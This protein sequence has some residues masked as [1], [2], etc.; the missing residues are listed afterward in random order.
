MTTAPLLAL[1]P[2]YTNGQAMGITSVCS[3]HPQVIAAALALG[4][5]TG[6][7]VLIEATCNQVNQDGGYTG[8]RPA[9][10]RRFV[11]TIAADE[12]FDTSLLILGGDHL[13]PNPWKDLP[14]AQAMDKACVMIA[15][16]AAAGFKKLHLDASMS[17][18][19]DPT[20]LPDATIAARSARLAAVA[21][22]N[23]TGERPV[24]V[25][26]TEVPVP[27]GALEVVEHLT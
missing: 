21:E 25:I 22:A 23:A 14:A 11:E 1:R 19:D 24:Y 12:D 8:M 9:D 20:P 27:G 7:P 10:F 4:R 18:A 17:C 5:T 13:G 26:G 3:A 6:R 16:Y 2:A 15:A